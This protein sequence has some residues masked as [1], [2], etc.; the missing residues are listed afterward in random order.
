MWPHINEWINCQML[1]TE[2][3]SADK[4]CE[5]PPNITIYR[6]VNISI[7]DDAYPFPTKTCIYQKS[8]RNVEAFK[9]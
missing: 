2:F 5:C 8:S 7:K 3:V 4:I 9:N 6:K 1:N